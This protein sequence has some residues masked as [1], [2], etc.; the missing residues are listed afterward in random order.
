[1]KHIALFASL[2]IAISY[3]GAADLENFTSDSVTDPLLK[4][5]SAHKILDKQDDKMLGARRDESHDPP[6]YKKALGKFNVF[7]VEP[8]SEN[9]PG[10]IDFSAITENSSGRLKI[11]ARNH[12]YGNCEVK[13][14]KGTEVVEEEELDGKSWQSFSIVYDHEP[15]A[16][17]IHATG[18]HYEHGFVTYGFSTQ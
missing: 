8:L 18:W 13:I 9:K 7:L 1:M 2:F 16:L 14:T 17:T 12:P 4:I 5:V 15:V 6:I 3:L 11:Y 10:S